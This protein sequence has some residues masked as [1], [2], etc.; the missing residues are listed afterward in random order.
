MRLKPHIPDALRS[1]RARVFFAVLV[2]GMIP[3]AVAVAWLAL[4]DASNDE[5]SAGTD[6]SAEVY[7]RWALEPDYVDPLDVGVDAGL[8]RLKN[9]GRLSDREFDV[10]AERV[11]ALTDAAGDAGAYDY[12]ES[13]ITAADEAK[14]RENQQTVFDAGVY[15]ALG[16]DQVA[17]L[18]SQGYYWGPGTYWYQEL[19]PGGDP[20]KEHHWFWD[21]TT[22]PTVAWMTGE[23]RVTWVQVMPP[24]ANAGWQDSMAWWY[25]LLLLVGAVA[26]AGLGLLAATLAMRGVRKPIRLVTE[27]AEAA[28]AAAATEVVPL[29]GPP[30]I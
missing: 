11:Q 28:T 13:R 1:L 4:Y 5:G 27:A 7:R 30:E 18:R 25:V 8:L 12:I 17:Q 16:D 10:L 14:Y 22:V 20:E 26:V 21:S 3:V 2:V 29:A 19:Q 6:Y 15:S 23:N 24:E 9:S